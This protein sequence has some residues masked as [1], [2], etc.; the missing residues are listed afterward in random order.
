MIKEDWEV[1][2]NDWKEQPSWPFP[3]GEFIRTRIG[4]VLAQHMRE[5]ELK[6]KAAGYNIE[7]ELW[8]DSYHEVEDFPHKVLAL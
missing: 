5:A 6:I 7:Q 3:H 8:E 2:R 4:V 1:F